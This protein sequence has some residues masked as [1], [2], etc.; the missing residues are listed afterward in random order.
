MTKEIAW[1]TRN[2][3]VRI[4]SFCPAEEIHKYALDSQFS[5]HPRFKSLYTKR[6]S[7]E[8]L[9]MLVMLMLPTYLMD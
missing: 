8:T 1:S 6:E 3:E 9:L 2:G 5:T 4:R 7:L